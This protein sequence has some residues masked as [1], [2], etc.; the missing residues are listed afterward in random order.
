M[1]LRNTQA[2]LGMCY[3]E[4]VSEKYILRSWLKSKRP[5]EL[6]A[7]LHQQ[8]TALGRFGW[9]SNPRSFK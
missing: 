4:G 3:I 9:K 6:S 5:P 2:I 8:K 1:S 7:L